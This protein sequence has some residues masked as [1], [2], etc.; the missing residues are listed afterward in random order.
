MIYINSMHMYVN[1]IVNYN[2]ILYDD[3]IMNDDVIMSSM[4]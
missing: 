3:V 1:T 4:T 2:V